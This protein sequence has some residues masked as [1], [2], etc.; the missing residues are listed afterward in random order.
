V[1][2]RAVAEVGRNGRSVEQAVGNGGIAR[3]EGSRRCDSAS[4]KSCR[5]TCEP[6][7]N[8]KRGPS[9]VLPSG[10]TPFLR[11]GRQD[12]DGSATLTTCPRRI[13]ELGEPVHRDHG[14]RG[15]RSCQACV[16]VDCPGRL[17]VGLRWSRRTVRDSRSRKSTG[18]LKSELDTRSWMLEVF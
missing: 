16:P 17:A 15:E 7:A 5:P 3:A 18:L 6:R 8:T 9:V 13:V 10:L 12:A 1:Q 11:Q 2:K 4:G 14:C